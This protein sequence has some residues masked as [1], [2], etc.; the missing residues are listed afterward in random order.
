MRLYK[1]GDSQSRPYSKPPV[2]NV[3]AGRRKGEVE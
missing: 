1:A 2:S 3:E